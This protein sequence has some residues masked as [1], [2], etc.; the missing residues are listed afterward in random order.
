MKKYLPIILILFSISLGLFITLININRSIVEGDEVIHSIVAQGLAFYGDSYLKPIY[1]GDSYLQKPPLQIWGTSIL[2]KVFGDQNWVYR[3]LPAMFGFGTFILLI[4]AGKL[5]FNNI[6][7]GILAL[8]LLLGAPQVFFDHGI[9]LGVQ[10]SALLFGSTL[11]ILGAWQLLYKNKKATSIVSISIGLI[12]GTMVK[13]VSGLIPVIVYSCFL[14]NKEFRGALFK[15][16]NKFSIAILLGGIPVASFICFYYLNDPL[17]IKDGLFG[18]LNTRL[19]GEGYHNRFAINLY[20][21]SILKGL[22]GSQYLIIFGTFCSLF[23]FKKFKQELL[24]LYLWW[25]LPLIIFSFLSSRNVWYFLPAVPGLLITTSYG[26]ISLL[27]F[28]KNKTILIRLLILL[29]VCI[30]C[31]NRIYINCKRAFNTTKFVKIDD[32]AN[33]IINSSNQGIQLINIDHLKRNSKH[34]TRR[35]AFYIRK[36]YHSKGQPVIDLKLALIKKDSVTLK[37]NTYKFRNCI[38]LEKKKSDYLICSYSKLKVS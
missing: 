20:I 10:D 12:I 11:A 3:V 29:S 36:I 37:D 2:L 33:S 15:N 7:I 26:I 18:S 8:F 23:F 35:E 24:Y 30:V 4:Y 16:L 1:F 21:D 28:L 17:A 34:I 9:K 14:I 25:F 6:W 5:F 13:W 32:F 38:N 31:G 27:N 19:M 22:Y